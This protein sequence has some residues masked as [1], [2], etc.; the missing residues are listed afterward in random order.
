MK[1]ELIRIDFRLVDITMELQA[2][3]D[4]IHLI[5]MQISDLSKSKQLELDKY[6]A[7]GKW[8]PEDFE[9]D[10]AKHEYYDMVEFLLP[11]FFW[12][13]FIVSLYAV[14][15][16]AVTEIARL[17]QGNKAEIL[18]MNDLKGNFLERA[19]K[20]YK[21]V[22][23]FELCNNDETWERIKVLVELRNAIAHANGRIDILKTGTQQKIKNWTKTKMGISLW[24]NYFLVSA[25]FS[26]ETFRLVRSSLEDLVRRY[27]EWDSKNNKIKATP[28]TSRTRITSI[29][30]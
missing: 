1:E 11:R 9:W 16:A 22:L 26:K 29:K 15:E 17:I 4:H 12:G 7:Q 8:T 20:Y 2:L 25:G 24:N 30:S 19:G 27:K 5:E 10:E 14:Y 28:K 21:S 6:L 3:E 18:A 23:N 13:S